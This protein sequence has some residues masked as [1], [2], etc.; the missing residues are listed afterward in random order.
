MKTEKCIPTELVDKMVKVKDDFK[1]M[2]KDIIEDML[3]D[4]AQEEKEV[5]L[6]LYIFD[7]K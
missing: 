4:M 5:L 7:N 1:I 3:K 2:S 6:R